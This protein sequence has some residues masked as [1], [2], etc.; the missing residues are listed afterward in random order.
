MRSLQADCAALANDKAS[1]TQGKGPAS[2]HSTPVL[3]AQDSLRSRSNSAQRSQPLAPVPS[4]GSPADTCARQQQL[5]VPQSQDVVVRLRRKPP[6]QANPPTVHSTSPEAHTAARLVCM[7]VGDSVGHGIQCNVLNI[8]CGGAERA[9][10]DDADGRLAADRGSSAALRQ[11]Q[12]PACQATHLLGHPV[13]AA[14]SGRLRAAP[15]QERGRDHGWAHGDP[16][17]PRALVASAG[18]LTHIRQAH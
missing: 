13:Q 18:P 12:R 4:P 5:S 8:T 17:S 6:T 7:A 11:P 16:Q 15:I 14:V 10:C 9:G 3:Q 1:Q 2:S